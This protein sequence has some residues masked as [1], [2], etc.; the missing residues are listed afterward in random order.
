MFVEM[1]DNEIVNLN[2]VGVI[3]KRYDKLDKCFKIH[4]NTIG[5]DFVTLK[6]DTEEEMEKKW[7]W[8]RNTVPR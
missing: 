1:T 2:N 5:E 4:V 6:F 3:R 8:L 7:M